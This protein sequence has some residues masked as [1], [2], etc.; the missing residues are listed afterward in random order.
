LSEQCELLDVTTVISELGDPAQFSLGAHLPSEQERLGII[1]LEGAY[2]G[3]P[4]PAT[5]GVP[6]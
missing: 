4:S 1:M 5:L 6:T 2:T 3:Y